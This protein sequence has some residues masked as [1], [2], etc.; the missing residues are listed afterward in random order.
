[1]TVR[2]KVT[3]STKRGLWPWMLW[4]AVY[5]LLDVATSYEPRFGYVGYAWIAI[6]FAA[7]FGYA[8]VSAKRL[9]AQAREERSWLTVGIVGIWCALIFVSTLS[10][11][12]LSDENIFQV[13]CPLERFAVEP[14]GGFLK[15]CFIGYPTR[16]YVLQ[17]LP[18]QLFGFSAFAANLGAALLFFPGFV[19]FAYGLRLLTRGSRASDFISAASLALM[20]QATILLRVIVYHDQTSQPASVALI[21][22]GL[23]L[24]VFLEGNKRALLL[25]LSLMIFATSMY[26]A[27]FAVLALSGVVLVWGCGVGRIKRDAA[28]V[29]WSGLVVSAIAFLQT[30]GYREDL[31]FGVSPFD[32][33]HI[34][35]RIQ[36]LI[37]FVVLQA[38]GDAFADPILH[39]VLLSVLL[40]G[41]F[42][43]WGRRVF[44]LAVWMAAVIVSG[45]FMGGMSPE[46]AWYH[47]TGMHRSTSIYPVL[48]ALVAYQLS[49]RI[50]YRRVGS[51]VQALVFA[52]IALPA[53]YS[54]LTFPYPTQPPLSLRM[55]RLVHDVVP[56]GERGSPTFFTRVDFPALGE[57]PKHYHWMDRDS[58]H[59]YFEKT[60]VPNQEVPKHSLIVTVDDEICLKAPPGEQYRLLAQWNYSLLAQWA[61]QVTTI[62]VYEF[63]PSGAQ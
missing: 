12:L 1:M 13:G 34:G 55:F 6:V 59:I 39:V 38:D 20:F 31:R 8:G 17:A 16:S 14:D 30:R 5:P 42:G 54:V 44:V 18:A 58:S 21:F 63:R 33:E 51:R 25:L 22:V 49:K 48:S 35:E 2:H 40:L 47:M 36:T 46:L 45:F 56:K 32:I 43:W 23:V 27:V 10:P 28:P 41:I 62:K 37:K 53:A 52:V 29:V 15:D 4:F 7:L 9:V 50:D 60:C 24:T 57:L 26:P 11:S 3:P 61:P 19:L